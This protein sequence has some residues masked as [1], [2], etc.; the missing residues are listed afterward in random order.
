MNILSIYIETVNRPNELVRFFDDNEVQEG[1][2]LKIIT[3]EDEN[4][5]VIA[6]VV[7]IV[8]AA[9]FFSW[10]TNKK[11]STRRRRINESDPILDDLFKGKSIDEIE[12]EVE[13]EYGV[14][15]EVQHRE[16]QEHKAWKDLS[17]RNFL[18]GYS[19]DDYEYNISD[20]KEPNPLYQSKW[21]GK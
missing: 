15:I 4:S 9:M 5:L 10:G 1:D 16:D 14:K 8:I 19:Q 6:A 2:T 3:E 11:I 21:K 20:V 17:N 13:N 12:K 18:K 7:I